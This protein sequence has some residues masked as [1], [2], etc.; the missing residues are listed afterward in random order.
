MLQVDTAYQMMRYTV[1]F[2]DRDLVRDDGQAAVHLHRIAID[3]FAIKS[4]GDINCKL[5][6]SVS[7]AQKAEEEY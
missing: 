2:F 7:S 4:G 6:V 1:T 3:D 5:S